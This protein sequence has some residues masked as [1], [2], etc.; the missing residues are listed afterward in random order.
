[1]LDSSCQLSARRH[2][3]MNN[4]INP[5]SKGI[6]A[7]ECKQEVTE[8]VSLVKIVETLP[9]ISSALKHTINVLKF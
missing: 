7:Q 4:N 6:D 3:N 9:N 1:M 5:F 8:V 2:T